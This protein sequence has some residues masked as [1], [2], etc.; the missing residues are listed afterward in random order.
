MVVTGMAFF[1]PLPGVIYQVLHYLTALRRRGYDPYYIEDTD[2]WVYDVDAGDVIGD[3][4]RNVG[5]V[6]KVLEANGF[7]GKWAYRGVWDQNGAY[8]MSGPEIQEL[9]RES[10]GLINVTG[11]AL[12]DDQMMCP[13]RVYIETDPFASQ[14]KLDQGNED[15]FRRLSAH[16]VHFTFGENIGAA[17]CLI[18]DTSFQ[19]LPTRQPVDLSLWSSV[20]TA[21]D[22]CSRAYRTITSWVN[23][24]ES[25]S[26]RGE[27]F[28]W[29][30]DSEFLKVAELPRHTN[31]EFELASSGGAC[32]PTA[33]RRSGWRHVDVADV[34]GDADS[35]RDYIRKSRGEF[36]VARDQYVRPRTGW[37]SDRS[38]CFLAAGKPVVTQDTAFGKFLPTGQGLFAFNSID[39]IKSA[40]DSIEAD[41][42]AHSR[43][44]RE[45]AEE[46]FAADKVVESIMIRAGLG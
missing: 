39:D 24:V 4:G 27:E 14:V 31:A 2:R 42:A 23:H 30:K 17:D 29:Q 44:A 1:L 7:A 28:F 15:E 12:S 35:Y 9:Y 6:A 37:F 22:G 11:Q 13:R 3:A 32:I 26:H 18:P 38:A 16:D 25:V 33:M 10:D 20:P 41:Y 21:D 46:F 5:I 8:G 19:W 36:T 43:A 45:I 34:A 40:I